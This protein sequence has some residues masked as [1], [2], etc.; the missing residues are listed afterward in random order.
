MTDRRDQLRDFLEG[1]GIETKI[2][3][4]VLMPHQPAYRH[5]P[6]P[7]VPVAERIVA[8]ILSLPL[9]E[10]ISDSDADRIVSTVKS[11]FLRI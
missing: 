1:R 2:K 11:F 3:H 5:L 8:R 6:K 7:R 10:K 4:P 9:H